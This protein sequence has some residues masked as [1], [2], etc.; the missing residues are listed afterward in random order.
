MILQA[1]VLGEVA[2]LQCLSD[3]ESELSACES[4]SGKSDGDGGET[5]AGMIVGSD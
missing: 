5:H 1:A 2:R 4:R 3:V